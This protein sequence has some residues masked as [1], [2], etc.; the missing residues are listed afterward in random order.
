MEHSYEGSLS[1]SSPE[2][3][4]RDF[5]ALFHAYYGRL[6]RLLYRITG[7]MGRAEEVAAEAFWRF[8]RKPPPTRTNLPGWLYRTAF[9]AALDQLKMER[10]RTRYEGLAS[11]FGIVRTP[12]QALE[13]SEEQRRVRQA[14]T[15]LKPEQVTLILLRSE[16]FS[17]AE[18]AAAL[19]LNPTS[20][21]ALLARA[22]VAFQREYVKRHGQP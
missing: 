1:M 3:A 9:R 11:M 14:L 21:G 7:D 15:G 10:R 13:Q 12:E 18:L 5:A 16:G 22:E 20:V 2:E 17:Y 19:D 4:T 8:C 6:A